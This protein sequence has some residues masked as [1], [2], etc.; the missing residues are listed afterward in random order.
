MM[1]NEEAIEAMR[2]IAG[3]NL[4]A[5]LKRLPLSADVEAP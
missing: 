5:F 1:G 3:K 4:V 2:L